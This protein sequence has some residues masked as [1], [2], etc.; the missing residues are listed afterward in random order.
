MLLNVSVGRGL[1]VELVEHRR[2]GP[3]SRVR[4][5][6]DR[7]HVAGPAV[8]VLIGQ[9]QLVGLAERHRHLEQE[10][11]ERLGSRIVELRGVRRPGLA[12]SVVADPGRRRAGL[13]HRLGPIVGRLAEHHGVEFARLGAVDD[14][15]GA[16][17]GEPTGQPV[18]GKVLALDRAASR[19]AALAAG[20]HLIEQRLGRAPGDHRIGDGVGMALVCIAGLTDAALE[21]DT[22]AL[23]NHVGRLVGHGVQVGVAAEH[24]VVAGGV[25]RSADVARARCCF[26]SE[27]GMH[28][29]NVVAA[30]RPLDRVGVGQRRT[31]T[32]GAARGGS[33]H[34]RRI[35]LGAGF[36]A[37]LH[38]RRLL[39]LD[40]RVLS[41]G[42]GL[43]RAS[44]GF[45]ILDVRALACD[46][47]HGSPQ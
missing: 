32:C 20:R 22:R 24:D 4:G 5:V 28:P 47:R 15:A 43:W 26:G 9:G 37:A 8:G 13:G 3:G 1:A 23:L 30:E 40:Q 18:L 11:I 33:M 38:H 35:G 45:E 2:P 19:A 44:L 31:G 21:L 7:D 41:D 46:A 10:R 27:M 6:L 12:D 34:H 14:R 39:A 42:R 25:G 16:A 29:R 36:R 17:V